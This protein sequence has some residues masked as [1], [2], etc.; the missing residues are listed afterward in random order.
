[1]VRKIV[2]AG[3]TRREIKYKLQE[4]KLQ[5]LHLEKNPSAGQEE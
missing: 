3:H 5:Q 1:V 2:A 4:R